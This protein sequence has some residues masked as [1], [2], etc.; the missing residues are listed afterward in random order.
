MKKTNKLNIPYPLLIDGGLSNVLEKQGCDLN[1]T[2]WSAKLL[3]TNP[4][5][6]IKA[7]IEYLK[8][9]AQ[10]ITT[11]SYQ[12]SVPGFMSF[13]HDQV[14]SETLIL[15][16][17][18]L[19]EEAVNRFMES[20]K[21]ELKPL[22]AASIGPYGAYL[23]DGSEY[24]GNYGISDDAIREFHMDRINLLD[25]SSADFF[26]FETIPSFQEAKVLGEI[27][28]QTNKFAWM[29]FSC[30]D[31]QYMNDG[32]KLE[33]CVSYF[34]DH[35]KIFALG[36]NCT[37]P[38]YISQLIRII[39][40]KS[41]TKKIIVYPNSGEAYNAESK[42]WLG[43]SD[44]DL[45]VEMAKEWIKLGADIIGGCCRIGTDHIKRMNEILIKG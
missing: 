45:F 17:I 23:A 14:R 4:E 29:S 1:H 40:A 31:K 33:E 8:A 39:K 43:L 37:A 22:I 12:A 9:G 16:S 21:R 35:P 18:L 3:E 34:A 24:H 13:G 30:K 38:K 27:L 11:S 41:G 28:D 26:A 19:A 6:I 5:A 15:K 42:T 7:H 44:P 32:T 36:V 10:C 25:R 20:E 2:L